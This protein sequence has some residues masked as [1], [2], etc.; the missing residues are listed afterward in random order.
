M[1]ST[2]A[3]LEMSSTPMGMV[4]TEARLRREDTVDFPPLKCT[5]ATPQRLRATRREVVFPKNSTYHTIN[6]MLHRGGLCSDGNLTSPWCCTVG[7]YERTLVLKL[8]D[9]LKMQSHHCT[10]DHLYTAVEVVP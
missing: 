9:V 7:K 5:P 4:V 3:A 10:T 2:L 1:L 8:K 6:F